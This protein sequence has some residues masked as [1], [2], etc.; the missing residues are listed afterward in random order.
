MVS[1]AA[2]V[3][4]DRVVEVAA[5]LRMA[6]LR[7]ARRLRQ[8]AGVDLGPA[9]IAALGTVERHGPLTPSELA[10]LERVKRPT[11]TRMVNRLEA[12]GLIVRARDPADGR[13]S[14]VS[15][16]PRG[17][18]LLRRLRKRRTAYLARR[19][20]EL[21]PDEVAALARAAEILERLVEGE[22]G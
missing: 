12:E 20:R 5:Q 9:L 22:R 21:D 2:K 11:A 17:L 3:A 15:A 16:S 8:E 4:D 13:S 18:E 7:T 6:I 14:L 10:D 19:L 1:T